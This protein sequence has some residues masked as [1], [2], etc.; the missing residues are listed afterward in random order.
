ML[1]LLVIE[2]DGVHIVHF[3]ISVCFCLK[4]NKGSFSCHTLFLTRTSC[5]EAI[6]GFH[7]RTFQACEST[8]IAIIFIINYDVLRMSPVNWWIFWS[9]NVN[10]LYIMALTTS[11]NSKW[12][13]LSMFCQQSK[14]EKIKAVTKL[15]EL[16]LWLFCRWPVTKM[17]QLYLIFMAHRIA[18]VKVSDTE[19]K[20][21]MINC[22]KIGF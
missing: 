1:G 16:L 3:V 22:G 20:K 18:K 17:C 6:D 2:H 10:E 7:C 5:P 13:F 9:I 11:Q 15:S 19:K 4:T 21:T 14:K 12:Y 8:R